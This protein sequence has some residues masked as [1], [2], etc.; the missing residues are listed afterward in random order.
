MYSVLEIVHVRC[1]AES[2]ESRGKRPVKCNWGGWVQQQ[3]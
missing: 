3:L 1:I 2:R